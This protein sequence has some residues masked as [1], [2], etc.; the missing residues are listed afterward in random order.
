M[1]FY[2]GNSNIHGKGLFTKKAI[3]P[4]EVLP[5]ANLYDRNNKFQSDETG[6]SLGP[7]GFVNHSYAPNCHLCYL[8]SENGYFLRSHKLIDPEEEL[9]IDYDFNPKG[10]KKAREYNPPLK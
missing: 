7:M 2:L 9:T 3:N 4:L 10:L 6:R 5:V 1:D 8:S